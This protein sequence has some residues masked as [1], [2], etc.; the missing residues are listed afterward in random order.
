M[1]KTIALMLC[2]GLLL[3]LCACSRGNSAAR[4]VMR[5]VDNK[6]KPQ[7]FS[8]ILSGE[9]AQGFE[10]L[11]TVSFYYNNDLTMYSA[12]ENNTYIAVFDL[13]SED[14]DLSKSSVTASA[15]SAY[16]YRECGVDN[17]IFFT[18]SPKNIVLYA[19]H[20]GEDITANY[21]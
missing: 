9:S 19:A 10:A 17:Q 12:V 16:G 5:Y 4:H 6:Y 2:V 7:Q 3:S 13:V 20:N 18:Y 11:L 8:Y 21:K 15:M 14:V 1:K